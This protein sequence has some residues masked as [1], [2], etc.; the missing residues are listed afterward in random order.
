MSSRIYSSSPLSLFNWACWRK[1]LH[2]RQWIWPHRVAY[3]ARNN[4]VTTNQN[5]RII[6]HDM[7]LAKT[8]N[9]GN[10]PMNIFHCK[11]TVTLLHSS[12]F[13]ALHCLIT[14]FHSTWH[15]VRNLPAAQSKDFHVM[16]H[17]DKDITCT[18]VVMAGPK[19]SPLR[20]SQDTGR[21]LHVHR[22][23]VQD[24][25]AI[26]LS[27][28]QHLPARLLHVN[29]LPALQGDTTYSSRR[30]DCSHQRNRGQQMSHGLRT[31]THCQRCTT[32][33]MKQL[34]SVTIRRTW[35][36]QKAN[37]ES[38]WSKPSFH[39]C[40]LREGWG[41]PTTVHSTSARK[42]G[43]QGFWRRRIGPLSRGRTVW[44]R[45]EMDPCTGRWLSHILWRHLRTCCRWIISITMNEFAGGWLRWC[46]RNEQ[47]KFE[48]RGTREGEATTYQRRIWESTLEKR[49]EATSQSCQIERWRL[50]FAGCWMAWILF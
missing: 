39:W 37:P 8:V 6:V 20:S 31:Y 7:W 35:A 50:W 24:H 11:C 4:A 22:E 12:H 30:R 33:N 9:L 15:S 17:R 21:H 47:V 3:L 19:C 48:R 23:C 46:W 28:G 26:I 36:V 45:F 32:T 40:N 5:H 49:L 13:Q 41:R 18:K 16:G 25:R 14:S 1:D 44:N 2:R 42:Y 27:I 43:W 38:A 34:M 10:T 29:F